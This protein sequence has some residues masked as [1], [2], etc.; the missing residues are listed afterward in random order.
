MTQTKFVLILTLLL[1]VYLCVLLQ[2]PQLINENLFSGHQEIQFRSYLQKIPK[3][4]QYNQHEP[5]IISSD[6]DFV[7]FPGSGTS[8]DPYRIEGYNISS[9]DGDLIAISNT[10]SYFS[11]CNNYLNGLSTAWGGIVLQTVTHGTIENNLVS[12]HE[13]LGIAIYSSSNI[14]VVNNTA[15]NNGLNG[16]RLELKS[17]NNLVVNNTV[18]YN[19]ADGIW[20]GDSCNHNIIANNSIKENNL[21][22]IYLGWDGLPYNGPNNNIIFLNIVYNNNYGIRLQ[23]SDSNM[24]LCNNIYNNSHYAI[25]LNQ[26]SDNNLIGMNNFIG[27]NPGAMSQA[28]DAG[29]DNQIAI[30]YWDEW[31]TPDEDSNGFVDT[32]YN[33][34]GW[35][36]TQDKFPLTSTFIYQGP[37]VIDGNTMFNDT[38]AIKNWSGDGTS[39]NPYIIENLIMV[40]IWGNTLFEI[41][42]TDAHFQLKNSLLAGGS[43]GI[44]L[45]NVTHGL[46]QNNTIIQNGISIYSSRNIILSNNTIDNGYKTGIY[47]N[48]SCHINILDNTLS[49][50]HGSGIHLE[51]A[52]HINIFDNKIANN[53]E[54]GIKTENSVNNVITNN[55][56][57]TNTIGI[58]FHS[59]KNTSISSNRIN[60]NAF[61]GIFFNENS[62]NNKISSNTV[63]D[64]IW[65][66]ISLENSWDCRLSNNNISNNYGSGICLEMSGD[67]AITSNIIADNDE[68]GI[69]LSSSENN[70]VS[71]NIL[72]NH[73]LSIMG[74]SI[75][76]Y[77]QAEVSNNT[78]N[79]KLLV[80]WN[81]IKGGT[82]PEDAGQIIL[83][84]CLGVT[85]SNQRISDVYTGIFAISSPNLN[86]RNNKISNTVKTG[87]LMDNSSNSILFNNSVSNGANGI[88]LYNSA[89]SIL[90]ENIISGNSE[91]GITL[92]ECIDCN[93]YKN[94]VFNN[95]FIGISLYNSGSNSLSDNSISNNGVHGIALYNSGSNSL[96]DNIISNNGVH[97]IV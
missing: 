5:I 68:E 88:V 43:N 59:S 26:A 93:V 55:F 51:K 7:R 74:W 4:Q 9:P 33:I 41:K 24:I 46:I 50:N 97:G 54:S 73:G 67:N 91:I 12:N 69:L 95:Q 47:L 89:R 58:S 15:L 64:N 82:V 72:L 28:Y 29:T 57:D 18:L 61:L 86:I 14:I 76:H 90:S 39:T 13:I 21:T 40:D 48:N 38:A 87:I 84:E 25:Y 77:I 32:P 70:T 62:S 85:A 16:I 44:V 42:N 17:D 53:N 96:S 2:E 52:S 10:K 75:Q 79:G 80:Y 19:R 11:I 94:Q 81:A 20:V 83:V 49:N 30:N 8:E 27:N 1:C 31:I 22:G 65:G 78:V 60:N 36:K 63:I 23:H 3:I 71:N 35:L 34:S 37:Y 56:I 66:G 92:D 6:S 45:S